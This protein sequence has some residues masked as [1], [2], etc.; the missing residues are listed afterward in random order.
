MSAPPRI[1]LLGKEIT[2]SRSQ[3]P[4]NTG[5]NSSFATHRISNAGIADLINETAGSACTISPRELGL[6]TSK[7]RASLNSLASAGILSFA[8]FKA[9]GKH[10]GQSGITDLLLCSL[11]VIF[12]PAIYHP[13]PTHIVDA[14]GCPGITIAWLA[15]TA[16]IGKIS[17][18]CLNLNRLALLHFNA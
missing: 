6:I 2:S 16:N 13:L 15:D 10:T 4:C 3:L 17:F 1:L 11:Q 14:I 18:A 7:R 8:E 12:N 9:I 5:T